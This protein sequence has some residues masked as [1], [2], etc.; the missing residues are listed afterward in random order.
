MKSR[1]SWRAL[2]LPL[3]IRSILAGFGLLAFLT[4][5]VAPARGNPPDRSSQDLLASPTGTS[6]PRKLR[7]VYWG[8]FMEGNQTYAHYYGGTWG[9]APWDAETWA[10]FESNAGKKVSVVHWGIPPPWMG[11]FRSWK[12]TFQLV[13]MAGDLNLVTMSTRS[14]RLKR[15]VNGRYDRSLR[16]WARQAARW[17]H[18]FFLRL[19]SE[20]NGRWMPYAPGNNGNTARDF[21]RMWRHFHRIA[22][23]K[24]A[25]N[26]TWVWCPNVDP[27]K[28]LVPFRRLYPGR[29]YVDWTCLDG[30]NRAGTDSFVELFRSSYARL[31]DLA[32]RKPI[33]VGETSSVEGG[34]GKAAWITDAL[35]TQLPERFPRIRALIWFNWRIYEIGRWWDWPIES[36]AS[37][38]AAFRD[39]IASAY[40]AAGGSFGGLPRGSKIK[41]P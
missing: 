27:D 5:G 7:R 33:M 36:S 34:E 22:D 23:R 16:R 30:Y 6:T 31:L 4:P 26:I 21:I 37:A 13:R 11:R 29:A 38:Q 2:G 3:A 25:T 32:P 1:K 15:I 39:S 20:M 17:G 28:N 9:N 40:Y 24:H 18:P 10:R 8:A 41:P 35:A 14:T 12:P 19:D